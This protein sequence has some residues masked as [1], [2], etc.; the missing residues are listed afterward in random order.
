M[1]KMRASPGRL[2]QECPLGVTGCGC[3][4]EVFQWGIS[5]GSGEQKRAHEATL[6]DK[7]GTLD[8]LKMIAAIWTWNNAMNSLILHVLYFKL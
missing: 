3:I 2:N 5:G 8:C 7:P 6:I 1:R 4:F